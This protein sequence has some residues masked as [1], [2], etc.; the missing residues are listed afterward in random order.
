MSTNTAGTMAAAAS[1]RRTGTRLT[2]STISASGRRK[3]A[4]GLVAR[5]SPHQAAAV[6][7]RR[8]S[9]AS[10]ARSVKVAKIASHC[11]QAAELS[12]TVGVTATAPAATYGHHVPG[13]R[14]DT[15]R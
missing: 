11:A 3:T 4:C 10:S 15:I 14:Y 9:S 13:R 12:T 8:R 1:A 7:V 2:S 6:S 5:A